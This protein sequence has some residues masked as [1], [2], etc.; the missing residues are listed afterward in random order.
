MRCIHSHSNLLVPLM[1]LVPLCGIAALA[2]GPTYNRG[3]TPSAEEIRVWNIILDPAGKELPPGSGTAQRG[4][5]IYAQKCAACH[6]PDG[7][8]GEG[9]EGRDGPRLVGAKGTLQGLRGWRFATSL[10][11]FINRGMPP[12][13]PEISMRQGGSLSADEVYA[14]TAF[15]LYRNG[16]IQ[17][18]DVLDAQSVPKVPMPKQDEG[19][20]PH[21]REYPAAPLH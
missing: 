4:A 1:A 9:R 11:D 15:L 16:I 5:E 8:G 2:Q 18:S 17:E 7:A 10:W 19:D 12:M 21:L 13:P 14:V 3:R 20:R 6:G